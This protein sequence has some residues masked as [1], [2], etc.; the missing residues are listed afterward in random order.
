MNIRWYSQLQNDCKNLY[1][2]DYS[3][4]KGAAAEDLR[5]G[6]LSYPIIMGLSHPQGYIVEGALG[7][8]KHVELDRALEVLRA[9]E[10]RDVCMKEFEE[11]GRDIQDWV[12]LW[13]RREKLDT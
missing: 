7:S 5:N 2:S 8:K 10:V 6:E 4:A 3:H 12:K 13:G 1:S 11:V 9:P